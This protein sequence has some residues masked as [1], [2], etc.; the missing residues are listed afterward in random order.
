MQDDKHP[1]KGSSDRSFGL[2][3]A[4]FLLLVAL[5]PLRHGEPVPTWS[6]ISSGAFAILAVADP[7]PLAR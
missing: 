5:A 3:F 2:V 4:A 6:L 7:R 1:I